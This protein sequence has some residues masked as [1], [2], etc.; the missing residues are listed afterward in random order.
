MTHRPAD[1]Q[2]SHTLYAFYGHHKC[3]TMTM[4][5]IIGAV[6][7]RLGLTFTVVFDEFQFGENLGDYVA[8]E[9]TDFLSYGNADIAFVRQ[10][11]DTRGFISFVTPAILSSQRIFHTSTLIRPPHGT[12]SKTTGRSSSRCPWRTVW[13]KKSYSDVAPLTTWRHGIMGNRIS[14]K[15]DSKTSFEAITISYSSL[16]VHWNARYG[17]FQRGPANIVGIQGLCCLCGA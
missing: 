6:C 12:N 5:A 17:I 10:L 14:S 16:L 1:S 11:P 8:A 2:S 9:G 15:F 4:N 3:A 7:R 13:R